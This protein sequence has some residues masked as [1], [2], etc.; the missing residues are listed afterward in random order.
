[1]DRE[2][3]EIT[4]IIVDAALKLHT[5]LGPGVFETVYE[6]LLAKELERRGLSVRR[7]HPAAFDFDGIHFDEGLR[8]DLLVEDQ[9]VVELKSVEKLARVHSKQLLT[10]LR[11]MN[12]KVG[13]LINFGEGSLKNGLHRIVNN[14]MRPLGSSSAAPSTD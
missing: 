10:Y 13:L 14:R 7:Q 4:G 5:A 2:V 1:M 9:I 8:I 11:L 3:N 6:A 12:L